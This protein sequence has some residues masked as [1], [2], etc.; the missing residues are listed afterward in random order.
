MVTVP[1]KQAV[2]GTLRW[3]D[4]LCMGVLWVTLLLLYPWVEA[5]EICVTFSWTKVYEILW[6]VKYFVYGWG[7]LQY[8][9]FQAYVISPN[10]EG[11]YRLLRK[12]AY[13]D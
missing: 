7:F 1:L 6:F 9:H 4:F 2:V 11:R 3:S 5:W 12:C 13:Y 8:A 10:C